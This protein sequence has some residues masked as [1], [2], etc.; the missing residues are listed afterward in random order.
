[1]KDENCYFPKGQ[2]KKRASHIKKG[3]NKKKEGVKYNI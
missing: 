1:M 2:S 3:R